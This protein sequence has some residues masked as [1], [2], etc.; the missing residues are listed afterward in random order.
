MPLREY[1]IGVYLEQVRVG[2]QSGMRPDFVRDE[3]DRRAPSPL[4]LLSYLAPHYPV[5][6]VL[7]GVVLL[8]VSLVLLKVP[9]AVEGSTS[10]LEHP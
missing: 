8:H 2:L 4:A 7:A 9:T 3:T 10:P 5:Q 1:Y 6:P